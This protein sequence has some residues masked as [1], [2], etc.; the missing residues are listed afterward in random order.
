VEALRPITSRLARTA[1]ALVIVGTCLCACTSVWN[2]PPPSLRYEGRPKHP[3]TAVLILGPEL[4]AARWEAMISP[5]DR[6]QIP[7]GDTLAQECEELARA[8]FERV[9]VA[10][11]SGPRADLPGRLVLI[12]RLVSVNRTQPAT[13]FGTQTTTIIMEWKVETGA[14]RLIWV[15]TVLGEDSR[16]MTSDVKGSAAEQ[17]ESALTRL[18]QSSFEALSSSSEVARASS[19]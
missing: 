15:K 8:T 18:Y 10:D 7:L 9:E 19:R 1:A 12:P 2:F 16:Q 13:I 3:A 5:V 6:A 11:M 14:G 17:V 4:R